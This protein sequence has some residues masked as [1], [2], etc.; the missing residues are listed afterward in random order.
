MNHDRTRTRYVNSEDDT[1]DELAD[2]L[3][4]GERGV[5]ET[6][7]E[8]EDA[9]LAKARRPRAVND[10]A[11]ED[12]EPFEGQE[13]EDAEDV[14]E[15]GGERGSHRRPSHHRASREETRVFSAMATGQEMAGAAKRSVAAL[16]TEI[17]LSF[18]G[19]RSIGSWSSE[20]WCAIRKPAAKTYGTRRSG[21]SE[22]V[23][24]SPAG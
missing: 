10:A 19:R 15:S 18:L 21:S 6:G 14:Q 13:S 9:S 8:P 24:E 12:N 22:T 3:A 5:E 23:L 4:E 1:S 16:G 11:P 2:R 20:R 7:L 17:V